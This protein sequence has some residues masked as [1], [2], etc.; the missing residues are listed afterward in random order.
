VGGGVTQG[1]GWLK[2]AFEKGLGADFAEVVAG[3]V[4]KDVLGGHEGFDGSA[5]D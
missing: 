4:E 2:L 5:F 3:V 1:L